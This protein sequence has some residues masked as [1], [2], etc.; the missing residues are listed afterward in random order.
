MF[1]CVELKDPQHSV[2][3]SGPNKILFGPNQDYSERMGIHSY[4]NKVC[5]PDATGR[6]SRCSNASNCRTLRA[7]SWMPVLIKFNSG[8]IKITVNHRDSFSFSFK[9]LNETGRGSRCLSASN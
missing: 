4:L 1:E 9:N 7:R 5:F 2:L 8:L 3:V 6:G